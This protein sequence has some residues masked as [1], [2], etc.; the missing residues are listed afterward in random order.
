MTSRFLLASYR[1]NIASTLLLTF[2]SPIAVAQVQIPPSGIIST[3]AVT[4]VYGGQSQN[5]NGGACDG[6]QVLRR[7]W[8][9]G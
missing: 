2:F 5:G 6:R 8:S 4:G 1:L 3:I 9:R 7:R